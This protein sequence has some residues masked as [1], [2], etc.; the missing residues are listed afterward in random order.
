VDRFDQEIW[1]I[2]VCEFDKGISRIMA[3]GSQRFFPTHQ[4]Y[5][6]RGRAGFGI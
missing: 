4:P 3:G 5:Q 6:N 2:R 1:R